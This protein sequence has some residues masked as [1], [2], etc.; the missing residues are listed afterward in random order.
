MTTLKEKY[1]QFLNTE[2]GAHVY[3]DF[4]RILY[5][6]EDSLVQT[7]DNDLLQDLPLVRKDF[8]RICDIGGGDGRR[9]IQILKYLREKFH[10]RFHVDFV[11]QSRPYI[12]AFDSKR[13]HDFTT[14]SMFH[15]LFENV[16]LSG[17]YDLVFLIHSIFAFQNSKAIDKVMSLPNKDGKVVIVSNSPS[18]FL[19]G[20]KSLIDREYADK[21]YE[22]DQVCRDLDDTGLQ[23]C[24]MSFQTKWASGT[25]SY[26][27]DVNTILEWLSLGEFNSFGAEKK[28]S[29]FNYIAKN[30]IEVNG[31]TYFTEE[32]I[33][34]VA[35]MR[36][37]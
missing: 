17:N 9:I 33:V 25:D 15:D 6:T 31:R 11:E 4:K 7:L 18:S 22:I 32:E 16:S 21:R 23:Y 8:L 26:V 24:D 10:I 29:V 12:N 27:D 37:K 34:V 2:R 20:L 28:E 14:I 35:P 36:R 30:S 13:I 19:A 3:N 1:R 5:T